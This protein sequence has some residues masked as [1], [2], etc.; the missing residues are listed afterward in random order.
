[1][2]IVGGSENDINESSS[3]KMSLSALGNVTVSN[4]GY[5]YF[6]TVILK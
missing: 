6:V 5:M 1:M 3:D 2:W 4:N